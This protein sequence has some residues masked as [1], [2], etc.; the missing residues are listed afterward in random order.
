MTLDADGDGALEGAEL[1]SQ[2][3]SLLSRADA[4]GDGAAS[5]AEILALMT[6]EAAGP[7]DQESAETEG[8]AGAP[9]GAGADG[10]RPRPGI[11]LMTAL[12][13][14]QDGTVS[15]SEIASA[16]ESLRSLDVDGDGR[17]T[18]DEL[19]PASVGESDDGGDRQQ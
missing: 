3:L 16:P 12:D 9:P 18:T 1:P 10:E 2:F 14:D 4:D 7:P 11:P 8:G 5:A 15:E 19:L 17:L 6:V 13:A